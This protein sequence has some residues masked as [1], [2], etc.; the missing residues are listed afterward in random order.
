MT[1]AGGWSST[2]HGRLHGAERSTETRSPG[3][4]RGPGPTCQDSLCP[5]ARVWHL[6]RGHEGTTAGAQRRE[7][8]GP[9]YMERGDRQACGVALGPCTSYSWHRE[10]G[11]SSDWCPS[12][13]GLCSPLRAGQAE[14]PPHGGNIGLRWAKA[15]VGHL[16]T[17][18]GVSGD[19]APD[20]GATWGT[21]T[22]CGTMGHFTFVQHLVQGALCYS[23]EGC[24]ADGRTTPAW[25]PIQ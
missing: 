13:P 9:P 15:K 21:A 16:P 4:E 17:C 23:R 8:L 10:T 24:P 6:C 3:E 2:G 14:T 5:A 19:R 11:L 1:P 7:P 25:R 12:C 20:G 18:R 22:P